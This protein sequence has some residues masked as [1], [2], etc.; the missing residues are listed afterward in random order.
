MEKPLLAVS[1]VKIIESLLRA[2]RPQRVLEWGSGW[3]TVYWPK[4]CPGLR[5]WVAIEHEPRWYERIKGRVVDC[6]D[7]RLVARAEY[8]VPLLWG[9]KAFDLIFV[10]GLYRR[11][12]LLV[13]ARILAPGG[14]VVLHDAGRL[15]YRASWGV[16]PHHE[17]L[18]RGRYPYG[19]PGEYLGFGLCVFW[20][21]GDVKTDDWCR[22]HIVRP[23]G[24]SA[25]V[26]PVLGTEY[27]SG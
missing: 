6:V 7:L 19:A 15:E 5:E 3:S 20:R 1:E 9:E 18:F 23:T 16:F 21:D 17:L 22:A 12:C 27:G 24:V 26:S 14:I 10:D 8:Y 25:T 4:R 13:A 11:A 2:Q